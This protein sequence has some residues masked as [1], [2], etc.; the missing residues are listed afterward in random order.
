MFL[1]TV[2][3]STA[4][5]GEILLSWDEP[6]VPVDFYTLH[7]LT[8]D[9]VHSVVG[10]IEG[11]IYSV[12]YLYNG[13]TPT[14]KYK[15]WVVASNGVRPDHIKSR[16]SNIVSVYLGTVPPPKNMSVQCVEN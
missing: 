13:S 4:L 9:K 10:D 8:P 14:G 3:V 15:F 2:S 6:E 16:R 7:V 5:A 1:L 11:F 12:T